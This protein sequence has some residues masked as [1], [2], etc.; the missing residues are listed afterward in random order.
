MR[1]AFALLVSLCIL[2][3]TSFAADAPAKKPAPKPAVWKDAPASVFSP[4]PT[5]ADVHYG[6]HPK[7]VLH[8]WKAES[9]SPTPLLVLHPRWGLDERQPRRRGRA[10]AGDAQGGDL[11]GLDRVQIRVGS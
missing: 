8:F 1:T 2:G 5:M 9:Q 4:A 10:A 6:P 7:Q 3:G 11:R